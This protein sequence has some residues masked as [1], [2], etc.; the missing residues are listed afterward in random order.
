MDGRESHKS[1]LKLGFDFHFHK[2][3]D[4]AV[5]AAAGCVRRSAWLH[6]CGGGGSSSGGSGGSG[7]V[8]SLGGGCTERGRQSFETLG[9][10]TTA[11]THILAAIAYHSRSIYHY[12]LSNFAI[13][14]FHR[15]EEKD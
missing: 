13:K 12:T 14:N 4:D 6:G 2:D 11:T 1:M 5:R 7:D 10:K 8:G 3:T 9:R 15:F